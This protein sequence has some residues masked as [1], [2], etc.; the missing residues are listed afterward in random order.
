MS[1]AFAIPGYEQTPL[2]VLS[3]DPCY[4]FHFSIAYVQAYH[5]EVQ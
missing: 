5:K 4:I 3:S 2:E 1:K